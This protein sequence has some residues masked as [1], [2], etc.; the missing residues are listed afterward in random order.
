MQTGPI[1]AGNQDH[2]CTDKPFPD[3]AEQENRIP[4]GMSESLAPNTGNHCISQDHILQADS[5]SNILKQKNNGELMVSDANQN[6]NR[7]FT[8]ATRDKPLQKTVLNT[9]QIETSEGTS[10]CTNKEPHIENSQSNSGEGDF[11]N[12]SSADVSGSDEVQTEVTSEGT[13]ICTNKEPH[14][15][16][17]QSNSGEGNLENS[18]SADVS[19]SDEVQREVTS[20][21]SSICTNKELHI[22]SSQSDSGE[23]NFENSSS[24]DVS[25]SDE[26]QREVT[27]EGSSICTN[28]EPHIESSQSNSGIGNFENS[29][30]AD[31]SGSDEVQREV[32]VQEDEKL[33]SVPSSVDSVSPTSISSSKSPS[34]T[35]PSCNPD[36]IPNSKVKQKILNS[37]KPCRGKIKYKK[38]PMENIMIGKWKL[39]ANGVVEN[40][41]LYTSHCSWLSSLKN[42]EFPVRY[43]K[44][45]VS[46]VK[47]ESII[48]V[49]FKKKKYS[50]LDGIPISSLLEEVISLPCNTELS[51]LQINLARSPLFHQQNGI[52]KK[53]FIVDGIKEECHWQGILYMRQIWANLKSILSDRCRMVKYFLWSSAENSPDGLARH[54]CKELH[55]PLCFDMVQMV[56]VTLLNLEK[57]GE[58]IRVNG[59]T[60]SVIVT[61]SS[62]APSV[63]P[64]SANPEG[65]TK[66]LTELSSDTTSLADHVTPPVNSR[67]EQLLQH[68]DNSPLLPVEKNVIGSNN[69]SEAAMQETQFT[70]E[71]SDNVAENENFIS[72]MDWAFSEECIPNQSVPKS[73][74]VSTIKELSQT[75]LSLLRGEQKTFGIAKT[76]ESEANL[77]FEH[78][79]FG[80]TAKTSA[81]MDVNSY[82]NSILKETG[83][84]V[85]RKGLVKQDIPSSSGMK[86]H[87]KRIKVNVFKVKKEISGQKKS[88][89]SPIKEKVIEIKTSM[90]PVEVPISPEIPSC[91]K[92]KPIIKK[93]IKSN[94]SPQKRKFPDG[95][96]DDYFMPLAAGW[97]REVVSRGITN[98][99]RADVYYHPPVGKKLRS[100]VEVMKYLS[101]QNIT[102]LSMKNFTFNKLPLG[103][104]PPYE[105]LRGAHVVGNYFK[106]KGDGSSPET[107]VED[108]KHPKK[109]KTSPG[110]SDLTPT[111]KPKK[112]TKVK[113]PT[114]HTWISGE[115]PDMNESQAGLLNESWG[116]EVDITNEVGETTGYE[117]W[118]PSQKINQTSTPTKAKPTESKESVL[119]ESENA[120]KIAEL[121]PINNRQRVEVESDNITTTTGNVPDNIRVDQQKPFIN[122]MYVTKLACVNDPL[123][124]IGKKD[125]KASKGSVHVRIAPKKPSGLNSKT[126]NSQITDIPII[127]TDIKNTVNQDETQVKKNRWLDIVE[128]YE[129]RKM[130]RKRNG[131]KN[132]FNII[133]LELQRFR[134]FIDK[135]ANNDEP[136]FRLFLDEEKQ[137]TTSGEKSVC[138]TTTG[139]KS[140]SATTSG[141]KSVSA[142]TSG[143]KSACRIR[144]KNFS[145]LAEVAS[146]SKDLNNHSGTFVS[147]TSQAPVCNLSVSGGN[148][149]APDS[150]S[151]N[152]VSIKNLGQVNPQLQ[153]PIIVYAIRSQNNHQ[154]VTRTKPDAFSSAWH[155]PVGS[156]VT[157]AVTQGSPANTVSFT[158]SATP[159]T[160]SSS[161]PLVVHTYTPVMMHQAQQGALP[162]THS[163]LKR[164][165]NYSSQCQINT[166]NVQ[167]SASHSQVTFSQLPTSTTSFPHPG[168]A[169]N[170]QTPNNFGYTGYGF[171]K[172]HSTTD[173]GVS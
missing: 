86:K 172:E 21:G 59:D 63:N 42:L 150:I 134:E 157:Q 166:V 140:V 77:P 148:L 14:I 19:G 55:I 99:V 89:S 121:A 28:K 81:T 46:V 96:A 107:S 93:K 126:G 70:M 10:I 141:E 92:E 82:I 62:E 152:A 30:S 137:I 171:Y 91:S 159:A 17:S 65:S 103:F 127:T 51:D 104:G 9:K 142:T 144:V 20:E 97:V 47:S 173:D 72:N 114:K 52:L 111:T 36:H 95:T 112:K 37:I 124:F 98:S 4:L 116:D 100:S 101:A 143:E 149:L 115:F 145:E 155:A 168:N 79:I 118:I 109:L 132:I 53:C 80:E 122:Y 35:I 131:N 129:R 138:A 105:L 106:K 16:S 71:I 117:G 32:D 130:I 135:K 136:E 64:S 88:H 41:S 60:S 110:P 45:Y 11:E 6:F 31:V 5:S 146:T 153:T 154:I 33:E 56:Y 57:R 133:P 167:Q 160:W 1:S 128:K 69:D 73:K 87:L 123:K 156:A 23:G 15:E 78:S 39:T 119:L 43:Y 158:S 58:V 84:V 44:D 151:E 66:I 48:A 74:V 164:P 90:A 170:T 94:I 7:P 75:T 61:Q 108:S 27:S 165:E 25:G 139:E 163:I 24:A 76:S 113:K 38:F 67:P 12:S 162:N 18:S 13:S 102:E 40:I 49:H 29:S 3:K 85:A 125:K 22:E 169:I 147:I 50:I 120:K 83:N 68:G 34:G 2:Q 54:I 26:V 8:E 161:K